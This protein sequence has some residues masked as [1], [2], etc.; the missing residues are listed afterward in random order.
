MA[1]ASPP[2][3]RIDTIIV[4]TY[5]GGKSRLWITSQEAKT[6]LVEIPVALVRTMSQ[7]P[8][9]GR[10]AYEIMFEHNYPA[11]LALRRLARQVLEAQYPDVRIGY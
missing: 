11:P 2:P 7:R 8:W 6:F 9:G 1:K 5:M 3:G 10:W 4:L